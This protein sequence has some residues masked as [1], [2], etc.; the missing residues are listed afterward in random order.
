MPKKY[1]IKVNVQQHNDAAQQRLTQ[2]PFQSPNHPAAIVQAQENLNNA[3][4]QGEEIGELN[5]VADELEGDEI[6]IGNDAELH[7]VF[8]GFVTEL[9]DYI[10]GKSEGRFSQTDRHI[11]HNACST[12]LAHFFNA[13]L[14][15]GKRNFYKNELS[16][17]SSDMFSPQ[18]VI[19][20]GLVRVLAFWQWGKGPYWVGGAR[21][22]EDVR[23][24]DFVGGHTELTQEEFDELTEEEITQLKEIKI[25]AV[26]YRDI[27]P[28][29]QNFPPQIQDAA[30]QAQ[31]QCQQNYLTIIDRVRADAQPDIELEG[32]PI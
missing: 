21:T 20:Y 7:E 10:V 12:Y 26:F 29:V 16:R 28:K 19:L 8:S 15:E 6:K 25:A 24:N 30:N 9:I 17:Y 2:L 11:F 18:H 13:Y 14:D 22:R 5:D 23:R 32:P 27:Y 31:Q 4:A 1:D 3:N